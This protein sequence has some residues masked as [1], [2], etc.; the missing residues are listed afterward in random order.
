MDIIC[1]EMKGRLLLL[2]TLIGSLLMG[3]NE[4]R[5]LD[6]TTCRVTSMTDQ[7]DAAGKLTDQVLRSFTYTS[8]QLTQLSER[9]TDRQA[10]LKLTYG[11]SGQLVSAADGA[12]MIAF[13]YGSGSAFPNRATTMQGTTVQ[14]T[15][16][17]AYSAANKLARVFEDRQVV[18]ANTFVRSREYLFT[19]DDNNNLI[20]EK[21]KSTLVDRTTVEQQTDYTFATGMGPMTNFPQP[22]L[23]TVAALSQYV[24]TMPG[25]FWQ[26]R[27]LKEYKSYNARNGVRSTVRESATFTPN[28]DENSRLVSLEQNTTSTSGS[29]QAFVRKNVHKF[30]YECQ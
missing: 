13:E 17:L 28:M 23:L 5:T 19:Y 11:S 14:A 6:P 24:E 8:G 20:T 21:L 16:E 12:F 22:V 2:T 9:N 10:T 3:C 4:E 7:L 26:E 18:P 29:G 27:V 25:R 1:T 30:A 15:Y